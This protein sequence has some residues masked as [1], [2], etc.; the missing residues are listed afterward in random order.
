[1]FKNKERIERKW[2]AKNTTLSEQFQNPIKKN[3]RNTG[4]ID[5][6]AFI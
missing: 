6:L 4:E 3:C 5:T 2:K 1:M